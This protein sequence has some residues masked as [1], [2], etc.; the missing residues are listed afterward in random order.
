LKSIQIKSEKASLFKILF[1]ELAGRR[2]DCPKV[3][4]ADF[5]FG[6]PSRSGLKISLRFNLPLKFG[7]HCGLPVLLR[8]ILQI[9]ETMKK[10][11]KLNLLLACLAFATVLQAQKFGHLNSGNI[12][13]EMPGAKAADESLKVF[14]D[15]MV[16][17]GE[18]RASKLQAE[19]EEFYQKYQ[20][21]DVPPAE[22][23]KK[24]AEFQQREQ[25]LAQYEQ[26]VIDK[27]AKKR[28]ELIAPILAQLQDAINAV[29]KEGGY[30]MIFDV[31]VFNTIL[32][33]K[34][35]DDIEALV[36]AKI[37]N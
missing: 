35:S 27:V 20:S 32:F 31:S 18:E 36:K 26:E 37:A 6:R 29:G 14:Q 28:Q 33:A 34:D 22:A 15:S 4:G 11:L 7:V 25:E 23:Q 19:F 17:I 3:E 16:T 8:P 12:L 2:N 30:T 13:A 24:Q 1:C 5:F 21:G 10:V 9:T